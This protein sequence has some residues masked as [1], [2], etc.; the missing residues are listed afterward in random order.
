MQQDETRGM[1]RLV[2]VAFFIFFFG[3]LLLSSPFWWKQW[4]VLHTW[5]PVDAEVVQS[6][7]S[8]MTLRG[9]TGYDIFLVLRFK[10]GDRVLDTTYRS[11]RLSSSADSKR[12]EVARFPIGKHV[13]ILYDPSDPTKVR[14]DPGYNLRFFAVPALI[15]VMGLI[16]ALAAT[17]FFFVAGR[18][19]GGKAKASPS[20]K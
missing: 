8:P 3:F 12:A 15:T 20:S 17:V 19:K 9:K 14:L 2:G 16:C 11:E 5:T 7:V 10:S 18:I 6:D 1:L 13:P 4:Q